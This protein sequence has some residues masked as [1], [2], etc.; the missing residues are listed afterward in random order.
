MSGLTKA[1]DHIGELALVKQ[2]HL[3]PS[4]ACKGWG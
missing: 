2:H 4:G 1:P 3:P